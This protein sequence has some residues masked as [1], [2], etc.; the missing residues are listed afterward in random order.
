MIKERLT[1]APP[2]INTGLPVYWDNFPRP[3]EHRASV[4]PKQIITKPTFSIPSEQVT[5]AY[6]KVVFNRGGLVVI[7]KMNLECVV[8]VAVVVR[9][10]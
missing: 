8:V 1:K 3:N 4:T 2:N 10:Q 7:I 5:K 6:K 9:N